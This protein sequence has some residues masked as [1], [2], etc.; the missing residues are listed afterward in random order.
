MP[1]SLTFND[2]GCWFYNTS[3]TA[4]RNVPSVLNHY[5]LCWHG[6]TVALSSAVVNTH[7]A[8]QLRRFNPLVVL[9]AHLHFKS[10]DQGESAVWP[11]PALG[12]SWT[13]L[14]SV[15]SSTGLFNRLSGHKYN[16][17]DGHQWGSSGYYRELCVWV[18]PWM[19]GCVYQLC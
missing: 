4:S 14:E 11:H 8:G 16:T 12:H 2:T 15:L 19:I 6:G 9:H 3:A 17:W 10:S 5:F 1:L 18:F 7:A 13:W